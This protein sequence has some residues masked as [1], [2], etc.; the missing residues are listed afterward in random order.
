RPID[1]PS[2]RS[3]VEVQRS[4]STLVRN[5]WRQRPVLRHRPVRPAV[6][7]QAQLRRVLGLHRLVRWRFCFNLRAQRGSQRVSRHPPRL[8]LLVPAK[9]PL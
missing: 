8:F 7:P 9:P 3:M 1:L 5:R 6:V 2:S 4:P